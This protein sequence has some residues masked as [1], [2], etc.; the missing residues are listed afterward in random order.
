MAKRKCFRTNKIL[1][2]LCYIPDHVS[3]CEDSGSECDDLYN[4]EQD[5][6]FS[7]KSETDL[8]ES[9][10]SLS[11]LSDYFCKQPSIQ[12]ELETTEAPQE[13]NDTDVTLSASDNQ[14]ENEQ[15]SDVTSDTGQ[16]KL[17]S[18]DVSDITGSSSFSNDNGVILTAPDGTEWLQITLGKNSAGRPSQQN[19]LIEV[20]G[21]TPYVKINVFAGSPESAL[22]SSYR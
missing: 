8:S 21:P 16:N 14:G 3:E 7:N 18:L 6:S 13:I 17:P 12:N 2:Y 15:S 20:S 19:I 11:D 1:S 22:A 9:S 5:P 4:P 10:N